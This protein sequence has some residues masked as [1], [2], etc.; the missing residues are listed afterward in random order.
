M[1]RLAG[2]AEDGDADRLAP[3]QRD[4]LINPAR[5]LVDARPVIEQLGLDYP[6]LGTLSLAS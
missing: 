1:D 4:R 6:D 3:S 2:V 5:R